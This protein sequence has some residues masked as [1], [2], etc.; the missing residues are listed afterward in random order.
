MEQWSVISDSVQPFISTDHENHEKV[1]AVVGTGTGFGTES[2]SKANML[3]QYQP[4]PC[5][6]VSNPFFPFLRE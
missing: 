2:L 3:P 4:T 5:V 1:T 6:V